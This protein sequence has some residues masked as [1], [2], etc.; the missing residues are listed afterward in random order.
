VPR[1]KPWEILDVYE[2]LLLDT[3][4]GERRLFT[5]A[6][7]STRRERVPGGLDGGES[8]GDGRSRR[9]RPWPEI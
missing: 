8:E 6:T 2:R 1:P 7:S 3:I 4:E 9:R 5:E